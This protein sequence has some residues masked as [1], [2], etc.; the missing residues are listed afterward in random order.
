MAPVKVGAAAAGVA[1]AVKDGTA[2]GVATW[3]GTVLK[4]KFGG[5]LLQSAAAAVPKRIELPPKAG[6][7]LARSA[8]RGASL[9]NPKLKVG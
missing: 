1:A 8:G 5:S 7:D 4:P 2:S 9:V 6:G 3:N